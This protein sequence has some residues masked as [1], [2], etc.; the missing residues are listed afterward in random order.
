VDV[1]YQ[2]ARD[3]VRDWCGQPARERYDELLA[4]REEVVRLGLLVESAVTALRDVGADDPA[5]RIEKELG[6]PVD[7]GSTP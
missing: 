4:L 5:D 7:T 2:Q 1:K 6:I 3:L